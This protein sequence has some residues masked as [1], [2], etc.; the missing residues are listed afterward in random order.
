MRINIGKNRNLELIGELPKDTNAEFILEV[1]CWLKAIEQPVK[2]N[3]DDDMSPIAK[4]VIM[5]GIAKIK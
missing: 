4:A 3:E 5:D 1:K 2:Q